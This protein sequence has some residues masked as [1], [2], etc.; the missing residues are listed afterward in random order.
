L[1]KPL[2]RKNARPAKTLA[3]RK[4]LQKLHNKHKRLLHFA[5]GVCYIGTINSLKPLFFMSLQDKYRKV[6]DLGQS[7]N[8]QNGYV[9][10]A[11]GLLKIGGTANTQYEKDL[12][13]TEIKAIGG[14]SPSDIEADIKVAQTAYYHKHKV[15]KGETLGKIAKQYYNDSSKYKQIFEANTDI[16]K[17]PDLIQIDQVLTIPFS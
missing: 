13:W 4:H 2:C 8:V 14:D 17:N 15:V 11:N 9:E 12:M 1:K 5:V 16:L 10:E 7:L 3:N 6:L